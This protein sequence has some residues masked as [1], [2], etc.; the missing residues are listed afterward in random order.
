MDKESSIYIA[1]HRGL[2]GSALLRRLQQQGYS[3]LIVANSKELDLR[4]QLNVERFFI[5]N[6]P[7]IVFLVAAKVGGIKANISR[8]ADF[9]Y[10]NLM[11]QSNII[12]A[13]HTHGVNKLL[14]VSS[15]CS[16][17]RLSPQPMK[18]DYLLAGK[19]EP[20]N[21]GYAIAKIAGMKMVEAYNRQHGASFFSLIFPNIYGPNDNFDP[22]TSHVISALIRKM[23]EAK[24][25]KAD[26]VEIWGTGKA[27][28]EFLYVDDV[29]DACLF[30]IDKC[31]GVDF[32]NIGSGSDVSIKELALIIKEGVDFDG[33]LVFDP[34]KPD[35][36]PQKLL[37]VAKMNDFGW[38]PRTSLKEGI[39]ITLEWYITSYQGR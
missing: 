12:H 3:N 17:P 11:I 5:K 16:Y 23:Y 39:R 21:E 35:G 32:L 9:I 13:A 15:S 24:I 28:R 25:K 10:D 36:M 34:E 6:R 18:E 22:D 27:K 38:K 19:P 20:T 37:D 30:F 2:V 29:S 1:G 31:Q 26:T 4:R 8:P 14:F 7:E 33:N